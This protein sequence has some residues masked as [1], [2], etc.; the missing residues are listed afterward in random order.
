MYVL[1]FIGK[2]GAEKA[3]VAKRKKSIAPYIESCKRRECVWRFHDGDGWSDG[4]E[5]AWQKINSIA[6]VRETNIVY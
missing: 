3:V 4:A 2:D 1:I 5:K 6:G